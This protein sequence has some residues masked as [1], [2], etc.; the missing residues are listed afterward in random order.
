MKRFPALIWPLMSL[1]FIL[2]L[3]GLSHWQWEEIVLGTLG[4]L[5]VFGA[6]AYLS[7]RGHDQEGRPRPPRMGLAMGGIAAFYLLSAAA[8]AIADAKYAVLALLA[9][10]IPASAAL[11]LIATMRSK[12]AAGTTRPEDEQRATADDGAPG[13]GMD[14]ETPLGDTTEHSHAER[15]AQPDGR[16][17]RQGQTHDADHLNE[18]LRKCRSAYG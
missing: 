10:L 2:I 17:E 14:H 4:A 11:L 13:I 9:G 15:V 6:A 5:G 3:M 1:A 12:T 7:T 18:R 16:L 8:A